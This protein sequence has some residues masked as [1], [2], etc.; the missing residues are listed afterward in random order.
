MI[1]RFQAYRAL[2]FHLYK[3]FA[4]GKR[5]MLPTCLGIAICLVNNLS[6]LSLKHLL[7]LVYFSESGPKE[8]PKQRWEIY[9]LQVSQE[10]KQ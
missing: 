2:F 3:R 5:L 7:A 10:K 6:L 9:E 1:I 8:V 4:K